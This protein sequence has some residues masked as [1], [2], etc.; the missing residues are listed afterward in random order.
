MMTAVIILNSAPSENAGR[1]NTG[2]ALSSIRILVVED[3][4][5][6]RRFICSTL[7]KRE[8]L[9]VIC[10]SADGLDAV[11]KAEELQPDLVL[12]DVG[13]PTMNGIDAARE[14]RT[15]SP[16]SKILFVTQESSADVAQ[17]AFSSGAQG[18]VVK[19]CAGTELLPAVETIRQG[20][21]FVGSGLSPD[22]FAMDEQSSDF[23]REEALPS[24]LATAPEHARNHKV[25]FYPDDDS[26]L[27]GFTR[28]IEAALEGGNPVIVVATASHQ[29]DILQR[30]QA[31]AVDCAAAIERGRYIPLDVATTLSTFMVNGLP[32]PERFLKVASELV[33]KAASAGATSGEH[34]RVAACGECA[35]TLWAQGKADAAIQLEHLWDN[36]ARTC[37]VDIL[38]G[39]V[40]SPLQGERDSQT[41]ERICAEH[42]AVCSQWAA[43]SQS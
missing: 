27:A 22:Q 29:K 34:L 11:R 38:C 18:Y 15:L 6:F 7:G 13:L 36:I 37:S 10:E 8:E 32:D 14:I 35:P 31:D 1:G 33:E 3:Y 16:K 4:Q 39:Y 23:R 12:L 21:R 30:L 20:G 41:Y 43:D 40:L 25:Q 19:A 42:S 24:F 28:F 26:L 2:A 5:P 9:Q 17:A